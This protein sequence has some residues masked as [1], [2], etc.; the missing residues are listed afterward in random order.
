MKHQEL[1]PPQ[2]PVKQQYAQ[3]KQLY[4]HRQ[5]LHRRRLMGTTI[6]TLLLLFIWSN[7]LQPAE[8]SSA[9]S[10]GVLAQLQPL[11]HRLTGTAFPLSHHLLRKLGHFSEFLLLGTAVTLTGTIG[12]QTQRITGKGMIPTV[13]YTGLLAAV[14]DETLQYF[15][16]G[17]SPEVRDI[18]IDYSGFCCGLLLVLVLRK[19]HQQY[20]KQYNRV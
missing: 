20:N 10:T 4:Q 5:M 16:P 17:R 8:A 7:S 15:S 2:T 3:Q 14:I 11:W 18:L 1:V 9:V 6:V 12:L 19:L 13:L